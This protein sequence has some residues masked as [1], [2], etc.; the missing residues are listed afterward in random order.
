VG[1]DKRAG[2]YNARMSSNPPSPQTEQSAEQDL[3]TSLSRLAYSPAWLEYGLL[4]EASLREQWRQYAASGDQNTEHYR[5]RAFVAFLAKS[6]ALDDTQIDRYIE[7]A[8]TDGDQGMAQSALL[9]LIHLPG[10]SDGQLDQIRKHPAFASPVSQK[11]IERVQLLRELRSV[12]L[13]S[14]LFERCILSRDSEVQKELLERPDMSRPQ[15]ER[16]RDEGA[17]KA[18]RNIAKQRLNR[19]DRPR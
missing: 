17:N 9:H 1:N 15:M 10:L 14:E 13:S 4:D 16:L 6:G 11:N 3:E 2:W 18:I 12:E 19:P 7:L 8:Q 5:Y